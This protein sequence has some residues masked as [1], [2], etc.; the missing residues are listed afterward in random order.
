MIF[1][2][3]LSLSLLTSLFAVAISS[4]MLILRWEESNQ[5]VSNTWTNY[6]LIEQF[7]H[8]LEFFSFH[9]SHSTSALMKRGS[10]KMLVGFHSYWQSKISI[11]SALP[12]KF[13]ASQFRMPVIIVVHLFL[14]PVCWFISQFILI[15]QLFSYYWNPNRTVILLKKLLLSNKKKKKH[16][17]SQWKKPQINGFSEQVEIVKF[18][19]NVVSL[20]EIQSNLNAVVCLNFHGIII[21]PVYR[22]DSFGVFFSPFPKHT[23]N[24][25]MSV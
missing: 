25:P 14:E 18:E 5:Q 8:L 6:R 23:W 10:F 9:R 20:S 11:W 4:A 17:N 7:N 16:N 24:A 1:A 19:C 21:V 12:H 13:S 3:S 22:F 2:L 15:L